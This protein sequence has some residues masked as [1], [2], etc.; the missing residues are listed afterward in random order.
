M[1]FGII[2]PRAFAF[3]SALL[4]LAV[5]AVAASPT[6]D[7]Y[8][9]AAINNSARVMGSRSESATGI[10][11]RNDD[12][13]FSHLGLN[14]PLMISLAF[15]PRDPR[16]LYVACLSGILRTLDGG[17]TWR[18]VTGWNETEPKSVAVDPHAPD[19]VY[20]GLPDGFIV[21]H[22]EG[23]T[24]SRAESGLPAR[25]KYTQ[26]IA[27]DRA[28]A[29]R[30]L[31]GCET[32][33]YLTEDGARSWRRVFATTDTVDDIQ[34]SPHDPQL[35]LAVTQSAGALCSRDG[36][37]TWERIGGI[38]TEKALYNLAFDATNSQRLAIASWTY[39]ILVSEDGG[40]TWTE[41]NAG[42]PDQHRVWRTAIDPDTGRLYAAVHEKA[43]YAS[44][45]FGRTW[46]IAGLEGSVIQSFTFVRRSDR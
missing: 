22:D 40:R 8:V 18:L 45:D 23:L 27:V 39:G 37:A 24:W 10:F 33:I 38:P 44:D 26:T 32:G 7:L 42:L 36:G 46:R 15:D 11:R 5:G 19:I 3:C 30:V 9:C 34:Q 20:A 16:R 4:G 6:H 17:E 25:G 1:K 13:S 43:L 28:R 12:G 14:Y 2:P 29:G 41:R 21:S 31:A 35:W